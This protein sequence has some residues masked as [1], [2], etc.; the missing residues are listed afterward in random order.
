[1]LACK[2]IMLA[3]KHGV[4]YNLT[5]K[6]ILAGKDYNNVRWQKHSTAAVRR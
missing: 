1:M 4:K 3:G 5:G 2:D 6:Q